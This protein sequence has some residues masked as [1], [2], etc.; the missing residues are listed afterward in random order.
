MLFKSVIQSAV[1]AAHQQET[2]TKGK[3]VNIKKVPEAV[4]LRTFGKTLQR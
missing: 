1:R 2:K 4:T 3:E